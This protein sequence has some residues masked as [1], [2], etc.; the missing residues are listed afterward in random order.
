MQIKLS[1]MIVYKKRGRGLVNKLIN[2]LPIELHIPG[3]QYCGPGTKL[4]KRLARGDLGINPLDSFCKDHDIVYSKNRENIEARH[5]A[6]K[7]LADKAWQ[8]VFD[9]DASIGEKAAAYTVTN[10]MK[11]KSKLGM[12]LKPKITFNKIT[13]SA[14]IV[15]HKNNNNAKDV[16]RFALKKAKATV[17]KAGGKKHIKIPRIL[18]VPGKIGGMIPFLIPLFA[19]LSATGALAGGA[20]GIAKAINDARAAKKQLEENQ[21]HNKTME[22]IALGKGLFLQ[23]YK[24]GFGLSINPGIK[25]KKKLFEKTLF[26][27]KKSSKF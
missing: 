23:P 6:D 4:K 10:I 8:R 20:A 19:G 13:K 7:V 26:K 17:K 9:K 5:A 25:K 11:A 16:I 27:K 24:K 15:K 12:G 14:S 22:S 21:R 1:R 3:Y 18:P 2:K